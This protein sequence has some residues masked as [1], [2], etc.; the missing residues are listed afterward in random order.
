MWLNDQF[1]GIRAQKNHGTGQTPPP[2]IPGFWEYFAEHI[3]IYFLSFTKTTKE[4]A[5]TNY[6]QYS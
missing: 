3:M 5:K 4:S 6:D 2:A 1:W